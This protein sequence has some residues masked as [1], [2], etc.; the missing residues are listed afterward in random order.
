MKIRW[1]S[2]IDFD[3]TEAEKN[4]KFLM[5]LNPDMDKETAI[6]LAVEW[7]LDDLSDSI[8]EK[9]TKTAI[10]ILTQMVEDEK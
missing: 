3:L 6:R 10:E 4:Y 8:L 9:P 2:E 5:K 1:T 7:N